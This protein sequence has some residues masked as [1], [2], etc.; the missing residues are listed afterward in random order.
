MPNSVETTWPPAPVWRRLAALL[1]DT[2]VLAALSF[3]YGALITLMGALINGPTE[4][5]QPMFGQGWVTLGWVL[6][7]QIFYYGFWRKSGQTIG[8]RTWR[9]RLCDRANPAATAGPKQC[10]LRLLLAPPL[11]VL[12]GVGYWYRIF[13]RDG[14]CLHDRLSGTRVLVVPKGV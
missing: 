4:A 14:D 2:F 12:G 11:L 8:M 3:A 10:L 13:D 6:T 7:L 1:Y 9:I 5:Y